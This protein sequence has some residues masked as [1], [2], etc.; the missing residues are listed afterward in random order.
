[1]TTAYLYGI[2]WLS[3]LVFTAIIALLTSAVSQLS[4]IF[5]TDKHFLK[6]GQE[7]MKRLQKELLSSNVQ[8]PSYN[9]K[10]SKLLDLNMSVMTHSMKP[11]LITMIPFLLIFLYAKS[12]VPL[13]EALIKLPFNLPFAGDSLEFIGTYVVFSMLFTTILRQI[14]RR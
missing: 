8:D 4:F 10:Q 13:D 1:M 7:E 14:L 5:F 11:T 12:V 3:P 6:H 2:T 9:E